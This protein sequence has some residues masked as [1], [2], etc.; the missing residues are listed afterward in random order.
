MV[1]N[2]YHVWKFREDPFSRLA[3]KAAIKKMKKTSA[4]YNMDARWACVHNKEA[5]I[6]QCY[7][8]KMHCL[9][10]QR[11]MQPFLCNFKSSTTIWLPEIRRARVDL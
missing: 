9:N 3:N 2:I 8:N 5:I 11:S 10:G 6:I 1:P 4:K 7:N